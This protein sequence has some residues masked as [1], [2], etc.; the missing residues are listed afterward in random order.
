ML[1]NKRLPTYRSQPP[2]QQPFH[3][4]ESISREINDIPSARQ[5]TLRP[6]GSSFPISKNS[7][8]VFVVGVYKVSSPKKCRYV[9]HVRMY[10]RVRN[11]PNLIMFVF[12]SISHCLFVCHKIIIHPSIL[13]LLSVVFMLLSLL[14]LQPTTTTI[15]NVCNNGTALG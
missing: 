13:C 10:V 11:F 7:I 3:S 1:L 6:S 8:A 5:P 2:T 9:Q 4:S 12:R 14:L 15:H